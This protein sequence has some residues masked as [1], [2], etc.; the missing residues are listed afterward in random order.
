MCLEV[1][2]SRIQLWKSPSKNIVDQYLNLKLVKPFALNV[3]K[4]NCH[5]ILD[6]VLLMSNGATLDLLHKRFVEPLPYESTLPI[7]IVA[8]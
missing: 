2:Q 6:V 5:I 1:P 8:P 4:I 3:L 7:K